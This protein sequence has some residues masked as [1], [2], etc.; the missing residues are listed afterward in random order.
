MCYIVR[1]LNVQDALIRISKGDT[2]RYEEELKVGTRS[3]NDKLVPA[4]LASNKAIRDLISEAGLLTMAG[5]NGDLSARGDENM[6]AGGYKEI[7]AGFNETLDAMAKP[8]SEV[9]SVLECMSKGDLSISMKGDYKGSYASMEDSLNNTIQSLNTTLGVIN[10]TSDE[11]ASGSKQVSSASQA[12]S[13]GATEQASAVEELTASIAEVAVQTKENALNSNKASD[14]ALTANEKAAK[15]NAQVKEL[16][17]SMEG[18]TKSSTDIA[19]IIKVIDDIAFQTNILALNASI[20][21]ARAGQY[22]KGFAVVA[23]EVRSL[24]ARSAEAAKQ[25]SDLIED[26]MSKVKIGS[27]NVDDTAKYLY[28][29]NSEISVVAE[30]LGNIASSSN[31]QASAISEIDKGVEQVSSVIQ[32]NSETA[33]ES[34]AASEELSNHA[35]LLKSLVGNFKLSQRNSDDEIYNKNKESL[36]QLKIKGIAKKSL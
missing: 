36:S 26:S 4:I 13:Q 20:E 32:T 18:I 16:L 25:T 33:E 7:I 11:V 10:S 19:K 29:I 34:A 30:I 9:T 35:E 15:G 2:S 22:G 6:F 5:I 3:S 1:L 24:A 31:E 8:I 27:Q 14:L 17:V 28:D 12:L 21:A 23:E